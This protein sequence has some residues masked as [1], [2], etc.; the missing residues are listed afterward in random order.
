MMWCVVQVRYRADLD[1]VLKGL[2]FSIKAR[3]KIGIVGR[4]GCGKSTLMSTLFRITEPSGGQISIDGLD[5]AEVP[6]N[7]LR[8][9]LALVP[10]VC[11]EHLLWLQSKAAVP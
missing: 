8:S 11:I 1:L 5:L 10:Q 2:S 4:T 9:K 3:E 7:Q 6:L